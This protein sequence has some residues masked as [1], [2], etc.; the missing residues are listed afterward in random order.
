MA[1][2]EERIGEVLR[3]LVEQ[4]IR[5]GQP[6]GSKKIAQML[7]N[8]VSSATVR[9]VM[10]LLEERGLVTSPH[11]SAGRIPTQLGYRVF[12]DSLITSTP[13]QV[14]RV[15]EVRA[16]LQPDKSAQ[17]LLEAASNVLSS[18]TSMAG[19]VVAPQQEKM[20]L[21]HVEFLPLAGERVLVILVFNDGE[22]QNRVIQ[23]ERN[24]SESELVQ[25]TNFLNQHYTGLELGAIRE[26]L[27]A[28]LKADKEQMDQLMQV[29]INLAA[30]VLND[31]QS[32]PDREYVVSGQA[33]L[34]DMVDQGGGVDRLK[35]LF[36]AFQ[37]K[38]EMLDLMDR[39]V[40][41]EGVQIFIGKESGYQ[42]LDDC[43][44]VTS[45]YQSS[46]NDLLGVLAVIGPT[47]M[48]YQQ[49]ISTVDV[50]AKILS[51]ALNPAS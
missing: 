31:E 30:Q 5:E 34:L 25:V 22:V 33:N 24:Y 14:S 20:L 36:E 45:S 9:N 32:E 46:S 41:A 50:T 28:E 27:V 17:E 44:V 21:R 38:R 47:R 7:A 2:G 40:R 23:A 35:Q 26:K 4:Y 3:A 18:M 49:V 37:Q 39:C 1:A 43:S 42:M 16:Q 51:A 13:M 15:E 10:A 48:P 8:P 19:I 6:V 12:V 11:T 29:A